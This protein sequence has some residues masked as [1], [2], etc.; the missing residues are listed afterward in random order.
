M[1]KA[2]GPCTSHIHFSQWQSQS[3]ICDI[4]TPWIS[5]GSITNG[6]AHR[7]CRGPWTV[8]GALIISRFKVCCTLQVEKVCYFL[9]YFLSTCAISWINIYVDS[10]YFCMYYTIK[11][12]SVKELCSQQATRHW[13]RTSHSTWCQTVLLTAVIHAILC[14]NVHDGNWQEIVSCKNRNLADKLPW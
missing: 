2:T 10:M 1:Q 12:L 11:S 6:P 8:Q 4:S 3:A 9:R 13:H 5:I 14:G 7:L